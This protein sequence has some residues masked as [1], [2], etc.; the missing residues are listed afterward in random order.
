MHNMSLSL[1]VTS[2][3]CDRCPFRNR[4]YFHGYRTTR[5]QTNLRSVKSRTG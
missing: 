4:L 5:R 3:L 2:W 1:P